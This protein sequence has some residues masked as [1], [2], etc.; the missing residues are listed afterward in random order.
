[1]VKMEIVFTGRLISVVSNLSDVIAQF[2][3][4]EYKEAHLN[5]VVHAIIV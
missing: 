3:T 5:A 1:M 4:D 2:K